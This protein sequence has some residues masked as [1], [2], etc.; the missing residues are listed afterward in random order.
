[1][2]KLLTT[3]ITAT[4]ALGVLLHAQVWRPSWY[5]PSPYDYD[6][7]WDDNYWTES[8]RYRYL[9]QTTT[10]GKLARYS[11]VIGVGV[12]S[13][14]GIFNE[15]YGF[16]YFTVTVDHALAGCTNGA[17]FVIYDGREGEGGKGDFSVTR[18][19]YMPTNNS[20]IVFAVYTNDF[21]S[22]ARMYWSSPTI[23]VPPGGVLK[24]LN[25]RYLNRSWWYVDRD[26]GVL[27][28]HFTNVIQAVRVEQNWT[29]FFYLCRDGA[30]STSNRVKEDSYWDMRVLALVA[31]DERAQIM[32]DDPLV[33]PSHKVGLNNP[34][35]RAAIKDE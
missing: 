19:D 34:Q 9:D 31:T 18:E 22:N 20:R 14:K 28:S 30:S 25:L 32:L 2:K 29:N 7:E 5:E 3:V 16:G 35:W 4:I 27:L 10:L 17:S 15:E 13:N 26:D 6:G 21:G 8:H 24:N 23:P 11:D 12:V 1:M 33:D